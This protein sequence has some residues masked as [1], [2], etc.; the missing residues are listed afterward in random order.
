MQL[1]RRTLANGCVSFT[2]MVIFYTLLSNM[3]MNMISSPIH[4]LELLNI[5]I[6]DFFITCF[7]SSF[8]MSLLDYFDDW[9][10]WLSSIVRIVIIHIV[11]FGLGCFALD[12]FPFAF[13]WAAIVSAMIFIAYFTVYAVLYIQTKEDETKINQILK[14]RKG[15]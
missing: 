13:P 10:F 2:A 4:G 1:I 7:A 15:N 11:V 14:D 12:M 3:D 8:F 9:S 6:R 5:V